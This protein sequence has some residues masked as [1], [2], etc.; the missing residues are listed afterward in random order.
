MVCIES[1]IEI[2]FEK[3][4]VKVLN[5][6]ENLNTIEKNPYLV[7]KEIEIKLTEENIYS[8]SEVNITENQPGLSSGFENDD[9][10]RLILV[11]RIDLFKF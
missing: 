6:L 4:S 11:S 9:D 3:E 7:I 10:I 8:T 5:Q 1:Y 2:I